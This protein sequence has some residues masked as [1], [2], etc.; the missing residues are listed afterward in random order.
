MKFGGG[1]FLCLRDTVDNEEVYDQLAG[2]F[3]NID[4]GQLRK[5]LSTPFLRLI[6]EKYGYTGW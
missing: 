1:E 4:I 2:C 6:K 5:A 3:K